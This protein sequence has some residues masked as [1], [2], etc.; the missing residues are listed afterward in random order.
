MRTGGSWGLT[1]QPAC[2]KERTSRLVRDN[3]SKNKG[4]KLL[5][6]IFWYW[7]LPL[8]HT[9]TGLCIFTHAIP[10]TH[11]TTHTIL[12]THTL[13]PGGDNCWLNEW[14]QFFVF[15]LHWA[16]IHSFEKPTLNIEVTKNTYWWHETGNLPPAASQKPGRKASLS[17]QGKQ[18]SCAPVTL[19]PMSGSP[20]PRYPT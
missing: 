1:G 16:L 5:R 11:H 10:H 2:P 9:H 15:S 4:E 20:Q 3:V 19:Y 6:K 8:T 18:K 12:N 13:T 17:S 14:L 7:S